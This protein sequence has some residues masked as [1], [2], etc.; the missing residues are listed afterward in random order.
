MSLIGRR[1]GN[2]EIKAKIGEGGMGTVYL[3]EHPLIGKRVAI[4]VLLEEL[5]AKPDVVSRFFNEAKA[6]NDIG[7]QNIVDVVDF[8]KTTGERN[9]EV[10][11]F[12]MEFL[13]G[14]ALSSRIRR[15]GLPFK[16]TL[17][18]M[19]Q[20]CSALVA[21]HAKGIVH[22]D[23]KPENIF[24]VSRGADKNFVKILDFGIAKLTA[25]GGTSSHKT[26]TGLVIGTPTYMSPEQCEGKGLIDHR[27]DVY[28]LGIVMFELLTGV[29]PFP[30]EGF[31]EVL[32]AHLTKEPPKPTTVNPNLPPAIE[33][34]VLHAIEKDRNRR[35][36]NMQEFLTALENPE[37][38]H[39]QWHGLPAHSPSAPTLQSFPKV[40]SPSTAAAPRNETGGQR[41]TTLEGAAAE[42]TLSP[43]RRPRSRAP[44][45]AVGAAVLALAGVGG[46]IGLS[47][48]SDATTTPAAGPPQPQAEAPKAVTPPPAGDEVTIIVASDPP[49]ARVQRA[50]KSDPEK[51]PTPITFKMH[52]GDPPFDIQLRADGYAP[53][54]RTITSDDSAKLTVSLAKLPTAAPRVEEPPPPP[55]PARAQTP[56]VET[57]KVSN[58]TKPPKRTPKSGPKNSAPKKSEADPD[59][60][61][62]PSFG[63]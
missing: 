30:G 15:A 24:L 46:W 11:Y 8:G 26:R 6:V 60:I 45:I 58:V 21:S 32:V 3:G 44:M 22:R 49:G 43:T 35:F 25:D 7:H 61:I 10:V 36:Q 17:H 33:S 39:A 54:M 57:P 4:K 48:K 52:R 5:V 9:E 1:I 41:P 2:Y 42:V 31:G 38:H 23:L 20:C 47:K 37:A 16:D 50:D 40:T 62:Q 27:S 53:Q 19:Q 59:G 12:I 18:I 34:I 56:K 14:E 29:V 55:E 51:Q 63:N 13:D 28:S